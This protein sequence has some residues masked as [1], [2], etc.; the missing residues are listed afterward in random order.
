MPVFVNGGVAFLALF[1]PHDR[2]VKHVACTQYL[3]L[4]L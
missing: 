2:S 4:N 1:L 3:V